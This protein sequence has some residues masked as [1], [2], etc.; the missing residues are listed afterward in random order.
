MLFSALGAITSNAAGS[1]T[2][3][4][5]SLSTPA[6][7]TSLKTTSSVPVSNLLINDL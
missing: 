6:M 4:V 7:S 5:P 1:L 3:L 2:L